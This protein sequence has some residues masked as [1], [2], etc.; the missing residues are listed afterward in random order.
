MR[1]GVCGFCLRWHIADGEVAK[2]TDGEREK[3]VGKLRNY[4]QLSSAT[5][6]Q[7]ADEIERLAAENERLKQ[8]LNLWKNQGAIL[9]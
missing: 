3:L 7:A 2:M 4:P 1:F 6:Q 9:L 8:E 5:L